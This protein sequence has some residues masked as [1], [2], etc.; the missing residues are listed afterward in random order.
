MR[1]PFAV[2]LGAAA[3]IGTACSTIAGLDTAVRPAPP[4]ARGDR[5]DASGDATVTDPDA[6]T[7]DATAAADDASDEALVGA[8]AC[9]PPG[10][11]CCLPTG[12]AASC[13]A[14]DAG[15][16]AA[17]GSLLLGCLRPGANGR[18]CCWNDA[19]TGT[20]YAAGCAAARAACIAPS[21]CL[22]GACNTVV[23][24]GVVIGTCGPAA[25]PTCP[26]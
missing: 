22:G 18:D 26:P 9:T 4:E 2:G 12:G 7:G 11:A 10:Q 23:C 24:K 17:S 6:G 25:A 15:A 3:L 16:C 19:G 14:V 21:D 20:S 5:D 1:A 8:C 13:V